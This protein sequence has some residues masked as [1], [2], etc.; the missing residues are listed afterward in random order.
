M[1]ENAEITDEELEEMDG[2]LLPDREGL[3]VISDP[4]FGGYTLPVEPLPTE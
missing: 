4:V 1:Q 3:S 2:E